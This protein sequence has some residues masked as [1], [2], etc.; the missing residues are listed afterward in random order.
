MTDHKRLPKAPQPAG[1]QEEGADRGPVA[2]LAM[3]GL[4]SIA[5]DR[6]AA[7]AHPLPLGLRVPDFG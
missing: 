4:S 5:L 2:A 7:E 6:P 3:P 1:E